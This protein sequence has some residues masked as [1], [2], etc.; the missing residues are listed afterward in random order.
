[1]RPGARCEDIRATRQIVLYP[2][3]ERYKLDP[4]TEV[5]SLEVLLRKELHRAKQP[6]TITKRYVKMQER[7]KVAPRLDSN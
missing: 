6:K 3:T 2:G 4:K 5:M 7:K 1:M